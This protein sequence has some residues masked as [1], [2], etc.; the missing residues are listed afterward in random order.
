[1]KMYLCAAIAGF[2]GTL[3]VAQSTPPLTSISLPEVEPAASPFQESASFLSTIETEI[4]IGSVGSGSWLS[5]TTWDCLCIPT[6]LDG[7]AINPGHAVDLGTDATISDVHVS[8]GGTLHLLEAAPVELTVLG[9][10]Q[11][12]GSIVTGANTVRFAAGEHAFGGTATLFHVRLENA[13]MTLEGA[14]EISGHIKLINSTLHSNGLMTMGCY[15]GHMASIDEL[16]S[17][18]IHGDVR[19]IQHYS[20]PTTDWIALSALTQDATFE[21]WD[22]ALVTTGFP[23]SDIPGG[24]FVNVLGYDETQASEQDAFFPPNHVT[25]L[26]GAGRGYYIYMD[27]GTYE[28]VTEGIPVMDDFEFEVSFTDHGDPTFDGFNLVGNPYPSQI[29]WSNELGWV[30]QGVD[31]AMYAW[32]PD[33]RQY[34]TYVNGI[35]INGGS[36]IIEPGEA[37]IIRAQESVNQCTMN[38]AAKVFQ[39]ALD[40]NSGSDLIHLLVSNEAAG[41]YDEVML[42]FEPG[43]TTALDPSKDAL[44]LLSDVHHNLYTFDGTSGQRIG[45]N[46]IA[47]ANGL[48]VPLHFK[49]PTSGSFNLTVASAPLGYESAC[50]VIED[51]VTGAVIPVEAGQSI[52]FGS[53]MTEGMHRFTL[54]IGNPLQTSVLP[55]TCAG[56]NDAEITVMGDGTESLTYTWTNESGETLLIYSE[57]GSPSTVGDLGAG[58]YTV[59]VD[60]NQWC[61]GLTT[62]VEVTEPEPISIDGVN[63]VT[64]ACGESATG[65]ISLEVSG[66]TPPLS[67]SWNNGNST[68]D[69]QGLMP[70]THAVVVT[71]AQGCF[72]SEVFEI[73]DL[74]EVHAAFSVAETTI[75]LTD[76]LAWV[77]I[78][79]TTTGATDFFWNMGDG[80]VLT[81]QSPQH[82]YTAVGTYD[83]D[84]EA[85]NGDC[86]GMESLTVQV[87][88]STVGVREWESASGMACWMDAQGNV[89]VDFDL[90]RSA[91]VVVR[92]FNG[93]G[94][95]LAETGPREIQSGQVRLDVNNQTPFALVT[96]RDLRSGETRHFK[97]GR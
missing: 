86:F 81:S 68:Q 72:A 12:D 54:H 74:Q 18:W 45:I 70:G 94:Q 84:L 38:E 42:K 97:V 96:V 65:S 79:N 35:S 91:S 5:P 52:L 77:D 82:A 66:G 37:F 95:L 78:S 80:T 90:N 33:R 46:H 56:A 71:D 61:D 20:W 21:V 64:P 7:V 47:Y 89:F 40:V 69:V 19:F 22:E 11:A 8:A 24:T 60:G 16:E 29:D 88:E 73:E 1:M 28:V 75:A 32:D 87:I 6:A 67:F 31:A 58:T 57:A 44:K 4:T 76:G 48:S 50:M 26:I 41:D 43:T 83:I 92:A 30:R 15:D 53:G 59:T 23:G 51:I 85:S 36:P 63:T 93:V 49:A 9:N 13:E 27:P 55:M 2:F 62:T 14:L 25:D 10:L 34:R 17:S 3:A 39:P